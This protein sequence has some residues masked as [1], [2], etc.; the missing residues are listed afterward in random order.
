MARFAIIKTDR[1]V[2]DSIAYGHV[3]QPVDTLRQALTARLK[4]DPLNAIKDDQ[5]LAK[6]R[7]MQALIVETD[8]ATGEVTAVS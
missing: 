2:V 6:W 3:G 1:Q 4:Y 8:D 5:Q 7:V